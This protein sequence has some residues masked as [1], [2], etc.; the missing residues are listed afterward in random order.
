MYY[1]PTNAL[2]DVLLLCYGHQHVSATHVAHLQG[3]FFQNKN[4]FMTKMFLNH[5]TVLVNHIIYG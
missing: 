3:D 2:N 4:T 5:S 1:R